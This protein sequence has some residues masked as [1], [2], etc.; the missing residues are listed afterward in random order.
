[1]QSNILVGLL[2]IISYGFE[3]YIIQILPYPWSIFQ[4]SFIIGVLIIHRYDRYIGSVWLVLL[5]IAPL[6]GG[7]RGHSFIAFLIS[8]IIS[9]IFVSKL[10]TNRSV[11]ALMG[12]GALTYFIVFIIDLLLLLI[13]WTSSLIQPKYQ[14]I[15][16]YISVDLL[17]LF[18]VSI[19]LFFLFLVV[20]MYNKTIG[21]FFIMN[22]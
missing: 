12:L 10:F 22:H 18:G 21:E 3:Q 20:R 8:A 15:S 11:Y 14:T 19:G 2:F 1:M 13:P 9:H 16:E 7:W 17:S 4:L 5:G 6:F